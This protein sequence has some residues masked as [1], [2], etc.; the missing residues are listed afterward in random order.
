M[1][2]TGDIPENSILATAEVVGLYPSIPR[3]TGLKALKNAVEKRE[4]K[5]IPNMAEFL[6]KQNFLYLMVLSNSKI[7]E[8]P[9][10]QS[11][12][13]LTPGYM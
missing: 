6:L 7:Q 5:H 3:K 9:L 11:V 10:V 1:G 4:Q 12:L 8:R 2:Q 13:P